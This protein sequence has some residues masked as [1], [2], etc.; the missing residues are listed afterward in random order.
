IKV[1]FH[2]DYMMAPPEPLLLAWC[3]ATRKT[4]GGQVMAPEERLT[5][6]Q[7]LR[8]VTIDA[9]WALRLDHE[10]GSIAAGKRADFCVLEDDPFERGAD[11]LKDL[12]IAGTVFEGEPRMLA[13]PVGSSI[14]GLAQVHAD[15]A[16]AAPS[17]TSLYKAVAAACCGVVDRCDV[18]RQWAAWFDQAR[19]AAAAA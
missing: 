13:Q 17:R 3:A 6:M 7:A 5:L 14:A 2:S 8:G 11:A 9:A 15:A 10:V 18:T 16:A 4:L 12:R 19:Q 1:S